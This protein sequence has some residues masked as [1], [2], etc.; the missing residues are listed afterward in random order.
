MGAYGRLKPRPGAGDQAKASDGVDAQG[1]AKLC[2]RAATIP[3]SAT[4]PHIHCPADSGICFP[5]CGWRIG[6][7]K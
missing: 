4:A 5:V 6:K 1:L 7:V 3:K 2:L